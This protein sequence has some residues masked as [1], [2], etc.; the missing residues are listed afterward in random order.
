MKFFYFFFQIILVLYD[1]NAYLCSVKVYIDFRNNSREKRCA[2]EVNL[3]NR[4]KFLKV[5]ICPNTRFALYNNVNG[6]RWLTP[7][8]ENEFMNDTKK[9][10]IDSC[11]E[12]SEIEKYLI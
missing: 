1:F 2:W 5:Q 10:L 6:R 9:I 8:T 7:V 11:S 4:L 12:W 3:A